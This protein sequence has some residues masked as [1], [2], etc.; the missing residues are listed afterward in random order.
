MRFS[1]RPPIERAILHA[2]SAGGLRK[3]A[4]EQPRAA[5]GLLKVAA[6]QSRRAVAALEEVA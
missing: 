2:A 1:A 3:A 5:K 6:I 4:R